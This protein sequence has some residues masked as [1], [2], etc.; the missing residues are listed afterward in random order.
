[1]SLP[2]GREGLLGLGDEDD[3]PGGEGRSPQLRGGRGGRDRRSQS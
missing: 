3:F 2:G 1:M